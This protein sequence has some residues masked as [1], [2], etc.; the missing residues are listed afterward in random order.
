MITIGNELMG[1]DGAG[2]LLASLLEQLRV[3]GWDVLDG[4]P[5]PENVLHRVRALQPDVTVV[6]DACD[7]NLE[8]G[9]VRLVS[10][11]DIDSGFFLTTHRLPL[12]FFLAALREVVSD[13]YFVGIQ[14]R[15][16]AFGVPISR[17]VRRAVGLI[18]RR[19][20]EGRLDF[21][22]YEGFP[23]WE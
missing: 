2:P 21:P 12:V 9:S 16:V 11:D 6:V 14:P 3:P 20:R 5:M 4:G 15:H 10:E 8:A 17:E 1:D 19:L 7:M 22:R 18:Y 23:R 13:V